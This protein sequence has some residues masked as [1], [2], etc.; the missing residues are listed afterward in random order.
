MPSGRSVASA[1]SRK[2]CSASASDAQTYAGAARI[3]P[4]APFAFANFTFAMVASV[5][6]PVQP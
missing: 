5:L 1:T 6:L 2:N 3:A 4:S